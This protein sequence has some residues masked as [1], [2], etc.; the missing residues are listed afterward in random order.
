MKIFFTENSDKKYIDPNADQCAKILS[1]LWT[2]HSS[3]SKLE[4]YDWVEENFRCKITPHLYPWQPA[5][6]S[7][8]I[9]EA[10]YLLLLLKHSY[11]RYL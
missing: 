11:N 4:F 1:S 6:Q 3:M 8:E 9:D 10:D 7:I 5:I 2:E